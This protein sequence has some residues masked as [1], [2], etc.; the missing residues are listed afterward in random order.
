MSTNLGSFQRKENEETKFTNFKYIKEIK[1]RRDIVDVEH[2]A[3]YLNEI[4]DF[5]FKSKL[6]NEILENIIKIILSIPISTE[7]KMD[8]KPWQLE[9][10]LAMK[11]IQVLIEEQIKNNKNAFCFSLTFSNGI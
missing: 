7:H 8:L 3:C 6:E 11:E 5:N 9:K 2:L 4:K 10:H 1:N